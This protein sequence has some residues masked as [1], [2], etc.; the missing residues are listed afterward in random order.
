MTDV[1]VSVRMPKTLL[2][3]LK[4]HSVDHDFLDVSEQLRSIVRKEW[5]KK[6]QPEL[7]EIEQLKGQVLDELKKKEQKEINKR[8]ISELNEIRKE[9]KE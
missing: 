6:V 7:R 9:L 2:T 3:K 1:L 4:Q 8:I 5:M